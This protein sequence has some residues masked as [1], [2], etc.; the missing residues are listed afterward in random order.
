MA[1]FS[2]PNLGEVVQQYLL[3]GC[4][5]CLPSQP[6]Q[7]GM[8]SSCSCCKNCCMRNVHV[9]N[10]EAWRWTYD[11][12]NSEQHKGKMKRHKIYRN[13]LYSV[14][15]KQSEWFVFFR[16]LFLITI[17]TKS[18]GL[19]VSLLGEPRL[20]AQETYVSCKWFISISFAPSLAILSPSYRLYSLFY[21]IIGLRQFTG[22]LLT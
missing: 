10:L 21:W 2:W 13:R 20:R 16:I 19:F 5:V 4:F 6:C 8:R 17:P 7:L 11:K 14:I 22:T 3:K 1:L 9:L 18:N 12:I 15:Q